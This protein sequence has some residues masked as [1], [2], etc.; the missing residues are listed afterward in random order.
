MRRNRDRCVDE[1]LRAA[2][3][4]EE[5]GGVLLDSIDEVS[6]SEQHS[7]LHVL[8]LLLHHEVHVLGRLD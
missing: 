8:L 6:V 5:A 3:R 4:L 1:E 7:L 2:L